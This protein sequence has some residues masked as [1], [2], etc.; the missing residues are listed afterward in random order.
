M[1][2]KHI[3]GKVVRLVNGDLTLQEVDAIVFYASP[4][5]VL[6][7]GYGTA[8][9]VRGGP[10]IQ[11]ALSAM[12]PAEVG[13]AVVTEAGNL[14]ARWIIH[15]VGPR[16]QEPGE[17]DKL[18]ATVSAALRR[19][20]EKKVETLAFPPMG[21]G[22]Y[23]IAPEVSAAIMTE[24]I[25]EHLKGPTSLREVRICVKDTREKVPFTRALEGIKG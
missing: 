4:N 7:S 17:E 1:A 16:F 9:A 23:G 11:K 8:I 22:F 15:A 5:L 10:S 18:R 3:S 6:G 13:T 19:A 21:T 20:D 14:K 24:V 2:E 25:T 12:A